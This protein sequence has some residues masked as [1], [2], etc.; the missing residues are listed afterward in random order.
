M[1]A[2][3][4]RKNPSFNFLNAYRVLHLNGLE[5]GLARGKAWLDW[6]PG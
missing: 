6:N 1:G 3:I 2:S 5:P 4:Q